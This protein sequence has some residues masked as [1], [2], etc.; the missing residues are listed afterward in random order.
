MMTELLSVL[1]VVT[2]P[3]F[4]GAKRVSRSP[5]ELLLHAISPSPSIKMFYCK[6]G[7]LANALKAARD[8]WLNSIILAK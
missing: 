5:V 8:I 4:L 6:G 1:T 2:T 3:T 7:K